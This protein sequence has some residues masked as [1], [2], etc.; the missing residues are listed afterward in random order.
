MKVLV[1]GSGGRE[2]ALAWALAR[3]AGV[4]EVLVAPGNGGTEWSGAP[5]LAPCM[6]AGLEQADGCDLVVVGPEAPLVAA[7]D[8]KELSF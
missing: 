5:G 6:R 7:P 2:H 4:R 8:L 1:V 3:S